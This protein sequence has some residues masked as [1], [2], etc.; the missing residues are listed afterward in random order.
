MAFEKQGRDAT[1]AVRRH[2]GHILPLPA[3]PRMP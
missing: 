2:G 3:E 1:V